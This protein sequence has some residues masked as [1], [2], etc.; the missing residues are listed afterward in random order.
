MRTL[1][2][3]GVAE[4]S[5]VA[6][7]LRVLE[8]AFLGVTGTV[9]ELLGKATTAATADSPSYRSSRILSHSSTALRKEPPKISV[10]G[11]SSTAAR[12]DN[13]TPPPSSLPP[14]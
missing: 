10:P 9:A 14:A 5:L 1:G 2:T 4:R 7:P 11:S 12:K 13:S 3:A 6:V 8:G